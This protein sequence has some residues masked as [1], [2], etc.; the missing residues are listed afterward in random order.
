MNR[1]IRVLAAV[2]LLPLLLGASVTISQPTSGN[3]TGGVP[4]QPSGT[5]S[6]YNSGDNV[7]VSWY[8]NVMPGTY[9]FGTVACDE[10][11][12]SIA[13]INDGWSAENDFSF[14]ASGSWS[15][16]AELKDSNN[17]VK[18]STGVGGSVVP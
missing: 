13:F 2:M 6:G 16:V 11:W 1:S 14:T 18:A 8:N 4:Q 5:A 15:V 12:T 7:I 10:Y 9:H 3:L 17:Q